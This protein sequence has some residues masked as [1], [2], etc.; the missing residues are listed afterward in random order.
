MNTVDI[1]FL[2]ERNDSGSRLQVGKCSNR[3]EKPLELT[4]KANRHARNCLR[5]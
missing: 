4:L 3:L 2:I 5:L 1:K